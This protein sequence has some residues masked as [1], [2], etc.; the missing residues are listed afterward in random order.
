VRCTVPYFGFNLRT[1]TATQR[2]YITEI[3]PNSSAEHLRSS[4]RATRRQYLGAFITAIDKIPVFTLVQAQSEL[5]KLR[6]AAVASFHITIAPEPL[7]THREQAAVLH[8]LD[9]L[10]QAA[11]DA[12]DEDD[13]ALTL[14]AL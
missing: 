8:D 7:P 6:A 13:L 3:A 2:A 1:D 9:L 10:D 4:A 14:D 12:P 11:A 5:T